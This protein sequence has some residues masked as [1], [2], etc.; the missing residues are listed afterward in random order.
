M[1]GVLC[2]L[3]VFKVFIGVVTID[4]PLYVRVFSHKAGGILAAWPG[5]EPAPPALEGEDLTPGP[6][7]RSHTCFILSAPFT[8][9]CYCFQN[10]FHGVGEETEAQGA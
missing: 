6:P 2:A 5:I 10:Y 4:L 1:L 3:F 7:G 9:L 8:H